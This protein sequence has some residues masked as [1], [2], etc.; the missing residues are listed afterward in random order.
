[1]VDFLVFWFVL[2]VDLDDVFYV[3]GVLWFFMFF[4]CDLFWVVCFIFVV[5]FDMVVFI[6]RVLVCF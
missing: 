2:F 3:V 6:L 4:G 5:D 1:M